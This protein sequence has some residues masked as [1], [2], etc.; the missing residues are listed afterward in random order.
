[1]F[2]PFDP[3]LLK[4]SDSYIRPNFIFWSMV[5]PT[6]DDEDS[7]DEDVGEAFAGDDDG[8]MDY[9]ILQCLEEQHFNFD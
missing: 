7:S 5:Q 4:L 2:F 9:G 8:G 1:M 3:C 6:Y